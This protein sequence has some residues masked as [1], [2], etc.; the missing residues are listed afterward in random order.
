MR[1]LKTQPVEA[2]LTVY[3]DKLL[4]RGHEIIDPDYKAF[5]KASY[6][7]FSNLL[8]SMLAISPPAQRETIIVTLRD[9]AEDFKS[10]SS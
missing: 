7:R 5:S 4:L 2:A 10:V 3:L 6:D 1:F 9:Y 8:V